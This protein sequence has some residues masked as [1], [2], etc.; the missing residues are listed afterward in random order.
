MS[1]RFFR[2]FFFPKKGLWRERRCRK[3]FPELGTT[4]WRKLQGG[5]SS[6]WSC[7]Q[8][9]FRCSE[10]HRK[11][12]KCTCL[13]CGP[14]L[15]RRSRATGQLRKFA[16]RTFVLGLALT[17]KAMD[18]Q[19]EAGCGSKKAGFKLPN[20]GSTSSAALLLAWE[21]QKMSLRCYQLSAG[22]YPVPHSCA[23]RLILHEYYNKR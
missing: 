8:I 23:T 22:Q 21:V 9:N 12:L 3:D 6:Y 11:P 14:L 13:C 7:C 5:T 15:L 10:S 20:L 16:E 18:G 19:P 2:K 1:F 4:L 17:H